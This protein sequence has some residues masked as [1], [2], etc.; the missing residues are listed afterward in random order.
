MYKWQLKMVSHISF[1]FQI[2]GAGN[3]EE[4]TS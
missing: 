2:T 4:L 1:F 3:F